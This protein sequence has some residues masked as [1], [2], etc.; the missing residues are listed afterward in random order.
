MTLFTP[1]YDE[2]VNYSI[3]L[4]IEFKPM[5]LEEGEK[6]LP[7]LRQANGKYGFTE[8]RENEG[9]YNAL[10]LTIV[11]KKYKMK[12]KLEEIRNDVGKNTNDA[13][14]KMKE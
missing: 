8:L 14:E 4:V 10:L 13:Y 1:R 12:S 7:L 11:E 5:P 2:G 6:L 3:R 9:M